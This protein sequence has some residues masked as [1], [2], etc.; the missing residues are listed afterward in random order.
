MTSPLY[1]Y[2]GPKP[3]ANYSRFQFPRVDQ[4]I[5]D[6]YSDL[7]DLA[8][9]TNDRF[10]DMNDPLDYNPRRN[11]D[12]RRNRYDY[13]YNLRRNQ[14]DPRRNQYDDYP[15]RN[16]Y[17]YN[18]NPRRNQYDDYPTNPNRI[19][20][21][22]VYDSRGREIPLSQQHVVYIKSDSQKSDLAFLVYTP[23]S[24]NVSNST[25]AILTN[26]DPIPNSGA[27]NEGLNTST[28][29]YT[30]ADNGQFKVWGRIRLEKNVPISNTSAPT[31]NLLVN[32]NVLASSKIKVSQEGGKYYVPTGKY[33]VSYNGPL[34]SGDQVSLA[35][36]GP[37]ADILNITKATLGNDD[38]VFGMNY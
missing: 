6:N 17:D 26:W 15:R 31:L 37:S 7:A 28:G 29:T 38:T 33:D 12:P 23:K 1:N 4:I 34:K 8:D 36:V 24:Y 5:S 25:Q 30:V 19:D 16:Q 20:L 10:L 27:S 9:D 21:P 2:S 22:R 11:Y 32:G 18:Y 35:I 3:I 13:N 14:Y